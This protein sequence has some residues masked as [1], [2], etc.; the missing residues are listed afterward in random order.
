MRISLTGDTIAKLVSASS[1]SLGAYKASR[2]YDLA[3]VH[4]VKVG[5][6]RELAAAKEN[7]LNLPVVIEKNRHHYGLVKA[8]GYYPEAVVVAGSYRRNH[9]LASGHLNAWGWVERGSIAIQADDAIGC[10]ELCEKLCHLLQVKFYGDNQPLMGQPWPNICQVY[11]FENYCIYEFGG[12]KYRQSFVLDIIDRNVALSGQ[13]VKVDEKFVDASEAGLPRTQSGMRQVRNPLPLASNQVVSRGGQNSD[14]IR[15][16]VRDCSNVHRAVNA[17]LQAIK[18]GLYKPMKPSFAP[19]NL[20]SD[21]KILGPLISA[22]ISPTDFVVWSE[23]HG[24]QYMQARAF[25]DEKRKTF[26]KQGIAMP[27]GSFPIQ[28]K[29]DLKNAVQ[30]FG[31]SPDRA[32]KAHIIRRAK[33]LGATHMLPDKWAVGVKA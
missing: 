26:A 3:L 21:G 7:G 20:S 13:S 25:S 2:N 14:L 27:D 9:L 33:A 1:D 28:T 4:L 15:M 18:F 19:V 5:C 11:P 23:R 17:M 29:G 8:T 10:G 31:R 32:T 12:Q 22:G 16:V 30:S 24:Q 6:P